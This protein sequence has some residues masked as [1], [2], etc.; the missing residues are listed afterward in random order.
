[1]EDPDLNLV[2]E[3]SLTPVYSLGSPR[4]APIPRL[5]EVSGSSLLPWIPSS[6]PDPQRSLFLPTPSEILDSFP[7]LQMSLVPAYTLSGCSLVPV[8]IKFIVL[9]LLCPRSLVQTC[10]HKCPWSGPTL[11]CSSPWLG[12]RPTKV[13]GSEVPDSSQKCLLPWWF[14]IHARTRRRL[15]LLHSLGGPRLI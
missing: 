10:F 1:M 13:S 11:S 8:P 14:Q 15:V 9:N 6:H 4:L 12:P 2:L 5:T 3:R 7:D